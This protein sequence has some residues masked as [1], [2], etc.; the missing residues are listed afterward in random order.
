[1]PNYKLKLAYDGTRYYGWEHQPD[2]DTVQGRIENVLTRLLNGDPVEVI[3][4][5]R[6]D[7]GVHARGMVA[8]VKLAVSM[9]GDELRD[10]MNRYLPDDICVLEATIASDRFHARYNA[11]GKTY[12][13][14]FYVGDLK[15]VFN[16]K[17]VTVLEK[18]PDVKKMRAAAEILQGTHDFKAFCTNPNLKKSTV[19]TVDR[20]E[21]VE[22]KE[23]LCL[24]FHG[25]GF[26]QNM[27]RILSG[28]LL[29]VGKGKYPPEHCR[30]ILKSLDRTAAGP[31]L[32]SQGLCLMEV[33]Y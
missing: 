20:I 29:D 5:G 25:D 24:Y 17:Y 1:M 21:I 23:Y 3:C 6:T 22:K 26:L 32:P 31:T 30:E 15:P 18:K 13:Y 9:T 27:V 12:C 7:A 33:E 8:N 10:Y 2:Q 16:R 4:A 19:R 14:T 28:T 11:V